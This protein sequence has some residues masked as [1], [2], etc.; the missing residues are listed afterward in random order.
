MS[1]DLTTVGEVIEQLKK[2]PKDML[3]VGYG[4]D[5]SW[6]GENLDGVDVYKQVVEEGRDGF[7]P[8]VEKH[9][10]KGMLEIIRGSDASGFPIE[11]VV[12]SPISKD[13]LYD[14]C[15]NVE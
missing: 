13:N 5:G 2:F 1:A 12:I 15:Y 10:S 14:W 8:L 11:V 4:I 7:R 9:L 3:V 6:R